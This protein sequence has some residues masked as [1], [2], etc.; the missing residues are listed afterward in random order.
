MKKHCE[1]KVEMKQRKVVSMIGAL[2]LIISAVVLITGC[3]Q[4]NGN[5]DKKENTTINNGGNSG[6]S[7]GGNSGNNG[8]NTGGNNGGNTGNTGGVPSALDEV[9]MMTGGTDDDFRCYYCSR[10]V[11]YG[12]KYYILSGSIEKSIAG[13]Y[14]GNS[15][16]TDEG[17]FT[18]VVKPTKVIIFV[19]EK[20]RALPRILESEI[21]YK[22]IKDAPVNK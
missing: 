18:C 13:S 22:P 21:L 4:A 12:V 10:G 14:S 20:S 19:G 5:K 15:C 3:P 17:A 1:R 9:I 16:T 7:T 8:S 11:I 2:I 6:G